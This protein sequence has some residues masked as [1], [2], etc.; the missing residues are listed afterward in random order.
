MNNNT[1]LKLQI[2][3]IPI[4]S[5]GNSLRNR[6]PRSQW[7][8][9]RKQVHE[10]NGLKCEICGSSEKLHCH[11]HWE[12]DEKAIVQKLVGLGTV[13]NM[14]HHVAHFGRSK[15]LA[16]QGHLDIQAVVNHF[17]KVNGCDQAAFVKHE[18]EALELF[19]QRPAHDWKV[20][21]GEYANLIR[22]N[23]G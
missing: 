16:A 10:R 20:D 4:S 1:P 21:F 11:E 6:I 8:K 18:K 3:L 22:K 15:Q 9:L 14:C 2:D 7:D 12:F 23:A 5:W 17:M 13:C 19:A